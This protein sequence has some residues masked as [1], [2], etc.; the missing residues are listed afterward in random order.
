MNWTLKA[1]SCPCIPVGLCVLKW[2]IPIE[3]AELRQ[4]LCQVMW[5][6]WLDSSISGPSDITALVGSIHACMHWSV[7]YVLK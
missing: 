3:L 6:E 7:P 1:V 2:L 5:S 4:W